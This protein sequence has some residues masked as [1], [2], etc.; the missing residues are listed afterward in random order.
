MN[1]G[2]RMVLLALCAVLLCSAVTGAQAAILLPGITYG[3]DLV[4]TPVFGQVI[5][6]AWLESEANR[7]LLLVSLAMDA[8]KG[9]LLDQRY[10]AGLMGGTAY[11]GPYGE[12][13][14]AVVAEGPLNTVLQILYDPE[15]R[16]ASGKGVPGFGADAV[17]RQAESMFSGGEMYLCDPAVTAVVFAAYAQPVLSGAAAAEDWEQM[18]FSGAGASAEASGRI[19]SLSRPGG[20]S[21]GS[22]SGPAVLTEDGGLAVRIEGTWDVAAMISDRYSE[23][24]Q[25]RMCLVN[26]STYIAKYDDQ[27]LRGKKGKH[28]G[29]WTATGKQFQVPYIFKSL[30]SHE[31]IELE[32]LCETRSVSTAMHLD[33]NEGMG[34]DEHNYIFVGR[35]GQFCPMVEGAGGGILVREKKDG[36]GYDAVNGTK[37]YRWLESE[38]VRAN[39]LM[40]KIDRSYYKRLADEAV[41]TIEK[42]GSFERFVNETVEMYV[43]AVPFMNAPINN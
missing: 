1:S 10:L 39:D 12:S 32:D 21:A 27:G 24:E 5:G 20:N 13:G 16:T 42:F 28:A 8:R 26:E 3:L 15:T 41:E 33:M 43:E 17:K 4:Y 36:S 11:A 14:Y 9:G 22:G 30:F 25:E 35:V 18:G 40:D 7:A 34:E 23:A 19:F 6:S 31:P 29:E 38:I 2:R 37:G